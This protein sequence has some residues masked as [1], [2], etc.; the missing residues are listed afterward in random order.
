MGPGVRAARA[1]G[2]CAP[3]ASCF[4]V[5]RR[6]GRCGGL[7]PVSCL[8]AA[9]TARLALLLICAWFQREEET[10]LRCRAA[11]LQCSRCAAV[12]VLLCQLVAPWLFPAADLAA[13]HCHSAAKSPLSHACVCM[14]VLLPVLFVHCT[15]CVWGCRWQSS[16]V[17][18]QPSG[19]WL[20][21]QLCRALIDLFQAPRSRQ[22]CSFSL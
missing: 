13:C 4:E 11:R 21:G 9:A 3:V 2:S 1:H 7:Q 18:P 12:F 6:W 10:L 14:P 5:E 19:H 22:I 8:V 17:Q 15:P 20:L 16:H